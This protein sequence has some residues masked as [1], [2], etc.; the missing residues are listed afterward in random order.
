MHIILKG[1]VDELA[2]EYEF[3][4]AKESKQFEYFCNFCVTSKHYL[5]RFDPV[6]ITTNE[7]DAS[8]DGIAIVIDGELITT[9]D[10]AEA[11]FNTHKSNLSVDLVITQVKSGTQFSKDEISNFKIGLDDFLSLEP[12]LPNGEINKKSIDILKIIF[13]HLNKVKNRSPDI[14]V[15]Y[16][17]SGTY[18][19]EKEISACFDLIKQ[20]V[21]DTDYFNSTSV[22]PLG[23]S[24]LLGIF[25]SL[26]QKNEEKLKVIEYFAMPKLDR[27][28][29]S[30][31]AIVKASEFV[32]SLITDDDGK[33]IQ[34]VFEENVRSFLGGDNI[35]NTGI[36]HTLSSDKKELFS[37]LNNGITI[38]AP[39]L[40]L[41][42]N[43]KEI[44][45]KNYQ[46]INGCQTS[47]TLFETKNQLTDDV[48]VVIKFIESPDNEVSNDIIS[49]TNSQSEISSESF[50]GLKEKAKLV[51]KSFEAHNQLTTP[52]NH[53]YFERRQGEYRGL[54]YPNTRIFDVKELARCYAAMYLSMPHNSFRYVKTLFSSQGE[55]LYKE[56]D[57]ESYYYSAALAL[58]KYN[59]LIKNKKHDAHL[60]AKRKWHMI[61]L[62]T[63]CCHGKTDMPKPN[64]RKSDTY[65][66]K[67]ISILNAD[68]KQ[69]V[70]YFIRAQKILDVIAEPTDDELK[71]GKYTS[72]I[73][74]EAKLYL[75]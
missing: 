23:R 3:E 9:T 31:I 60:Y 27:I 51:Q 17:T 13:K 18:K 45:L 19:S 70:D 57:H 68:D 71:R 16:C 58:Y 34:S 22:K 38:V 52:E 55:N 67:V 25:N 26:T 44:H 15:Y 69:Y 8:L 64:A 36:H 35:V 40:T 47:N 50:Y 5:G 7:D 24:D 32:N 6:D 42:A 29:Q 56:D 39:E 49:A 63:W 72:K 1:Q 37:V 11:A 61:M 10:D 14:S 43:T 66:K 54:G 75:K 73:I 59:L 20:D 28:P 74:E 48:N 21:K 65:A 4:S 62:F 12:K 30:Y 33:L 53:I 2:K 41:S 46:I